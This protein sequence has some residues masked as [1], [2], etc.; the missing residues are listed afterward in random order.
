ML[1]RSREAQQE[2][3]QAGG[4]AQEVLPPEERPSARKGDAVLEPSQEPQQT[5]G[6]ARQEVQLA[7]GRAHEVPPPAAVGA[8]RASAT[9]C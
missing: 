8:E 5:G 4:R 1:M 9:R 3:Q 2:A 7:G 6:R